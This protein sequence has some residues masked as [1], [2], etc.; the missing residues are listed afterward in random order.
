M[1]PDPWAA[2]RADTEELPGT[3]PRQQ[4]NRYFIFSSSFVSVVPFLLQLAFSIIAKMLR[5]ISANSDVV[6]LF[7]RGNFGQRLVA[8][9]LQQGSG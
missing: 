7:W 9:E 1:R 2:A 3:V 5:V 6:L 8:A 4:L